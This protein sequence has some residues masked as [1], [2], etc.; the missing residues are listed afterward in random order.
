MVI[1]IEKDWIKKYI[2]HFFDKIKNKTKN[3]TTRHGP[4]RT[5]VASSERYEYTEINNFIN[6]REGILRKML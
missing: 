2:F 3:N 6:L 4:K 1:V 5:I